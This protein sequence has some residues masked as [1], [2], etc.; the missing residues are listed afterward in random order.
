[1]SHMRTLSTET[2]AQSSIIRTAY[3]PRPVIDPNRPEQKS[4]TIKEHIGLLCDCDDLQ[5]HAR[6]VY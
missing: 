5:L 2:K 4:K 6:H 1:M 3:Y